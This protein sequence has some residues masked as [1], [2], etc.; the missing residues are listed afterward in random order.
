MQITTVLK[1]QWDLAMAEQVS[2]GRL[3]TQARF[4]YLENP[5]GI[6]G[7]QSGTGIGFFFPLSCF[8]LLVPFHQRSILSR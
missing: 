1:S 8:R 2:P 7:G 3:T 4:W 5:R 6:C